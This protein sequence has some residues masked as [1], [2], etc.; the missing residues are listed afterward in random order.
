[1]SDRVVAVPRIAEP[2]L[3]GEG[4]L[5][6]GAAAVQVRVAGP[7]RR[8]DLGAAAGTLYMSMRAESLDRDRSQVWLRVQSGGQTVLTLRIA[9]PDRVY[10][11]RGGRW[12]SEPRVT[13]RSGPLG[14]ELALPYALMPRDT[15]VSLQVD[16][17]RR[18]VVVQRVTP[19]SC[20][21][22]ER[23]GA[24]SLVYAV[25]A[26]SDVRGCARIFPEAFHETIRHV[27]GRR[28][29]QV[30]VE[31]IFHLL[32]RADPKALWVARRAGRVAGYVFAPAD[33]KVVWRTAVRGGY[34]WRWAG[35]WL[36]GRYKVGLAPLGVI[37]LDKFHFLRA[38]LSDEHAV[39][40]R[41]LSIA[42]AGDAQGMGV[43]TRLVVHALERMRRLG[44][45]KVR[46][47][48]RPEN[49]PAR[50]IYEKLGFQAV[51]TTRDSQ[52]AW[53]IMTMQLEPP[54]AAPPPATTS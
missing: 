21:L 9:L 50:R 8:F 5:W 19:L 41:I 44:V 16:V 12:R 51:D 27:F 18:Y 37:L 24:E 43:G 11:R 32:H 6:P 15:V 49:R 42:V 35:L 45:P 46:L 34:L 47:E 28:P 7:L 33:L 36:R 52:G 14:I 2:C 30:M 54:S 10:V 3:D 38:A 29:P 23:E 48:V 13:A 20:V 53:L 17:V 22:P 40:A 1:M 25:A 26:R 39:P 4:R 31:Q